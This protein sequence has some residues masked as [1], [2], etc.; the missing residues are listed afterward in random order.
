MTTTTQGDGMETGMEQREEQV[1]QEGNDTTGGGGDQAGKGALGARRRR[2]EGGVSNVIAKLERNIANGQ[3]YEAHQMYRTVYYR[4]KSQGKVQECY[5]LLLSGATRLLQHGEE[6]SGSDL[7][8]LLVA[9]YVE[10]REKVNGEALE[11]VTTIFNTFPAPPVG[12]DEEEEKDAGGIVG[13]LATLEQDKEKDKEQ[14]QNQG[15]EA[16]GSSNKRTRPATLRSDFVRAALKW[17]KKEGR[18]RRG[19]PNLHHIVGKKLWSE[20][21]YA[22]AQSHFV[23]G[24]DDLSPTALGEMLVHWSL[25]GYRS[26]YDLFIARA[27][28]QLLCLRNLKFAN[29]TFSTFVK[30]HPDVTTPPY[31]SPLMN[32]IYF[33]LKTCER[34]APEL[35]MTLQEKY[36]TV[37]SRD[38]IFNRY[39]TKIGEVMFNIMPPRPAVGGIFGDM[40]RNMLA[41]PG[42]GGNAGGGPP[43]FPPL[44]FPPS[45]RPPQGR[46]PQQ[47]PPSG[48]D[49]D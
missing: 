47:R 9:L 17:T 22:S 31:K 4:L 48:A 30:K 49:L 45:Q 19:D 1:P 12:V 40:L 39:L 27:V 18:N 37:L 35:F 3:Y 34:D 14:N 5:S 28:L 16:A 2:R 20:G 36:K 23:F 25:N 41:G 11:R 7:A 43:G 10:V 38:P 42:A 21:R 15:Q 44:M 33:L 46:P 13:L 24:C 6:T 29:I 8:M 32:F 26:E